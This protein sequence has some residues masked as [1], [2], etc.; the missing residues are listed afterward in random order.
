MQL[1]FPVAIATVMVFPSNWLLIFSV[2]LLGVLV[3]VASL[4]NKYVSFPRQSEFLNALL[5]GF[6]MVFPPISLVIIPYL[7]N[8]AS[9]NLKSYLCST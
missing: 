2:C 8:K 6:C 3:P 5:I 4:L 7:A 1:Y 9:E